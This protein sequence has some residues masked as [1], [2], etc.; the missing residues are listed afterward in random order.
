VRIYK[1]FGTPFVS[2]WDPRAGYAWW[3]DPGF[4]T[5]ADYFR[6][7]RAFVQPIYN[8]ALSVPD[9]L[10]A[11]LW[12]DAQLG[13]PVAADFRS[14]WS[15]DFMSVGYLLAIVPSICLLAGFAVVL[16]RTL[17]RFDV[18]WM[19]LMAIFVGVMGAIVLLTLRVPHFGSAKAFYALMTLTPFCAL[20]V[21]G[22]D[23]L[24]FGNRL[25]WR[26]ITG[27]LVVVA[28]NSYASYWVRTSDPAARTVI[29]ARL[30]DMRDYKRAEALLQSALKTDP[31]H[32]EAR[33]VVDKP[34][35][36][37]LR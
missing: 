22:I 34:G 1:N 2:N 6:F 12:G 16:A 25:A 4:H 11:T 21:V 33:L 13:G 35:W 18:A 5:S 29:A 30:F 9:T 23:A 17:R 10:Y 14:P 7:G 31:G 36:R 28:L 20:A 24:S 8:I 19:M 27:L 32:V 37:C 3:Q 26:V 15:Y